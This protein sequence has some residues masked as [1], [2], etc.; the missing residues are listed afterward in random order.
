[1]HNQSAQTRKICKENSLSSNFFLT[2]YIRKSGWELLWLW[3][4]TPAQNPDRR[5]EGENSFGR[6][7]EWLG[8]ERSMIQCLRAFY[9]SDA[10]ASKSL[11]FALSNQSEFFWCL[12]PLD[13]RVQLISMGNHS[14]HLLCR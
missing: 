12:F 6:G 4:R 11:Y 10:L 3:R 2:L 1:M 8:R 9:H 13:R 7:V 5:I 14:T